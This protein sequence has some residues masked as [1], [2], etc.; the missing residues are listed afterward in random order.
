VDAPAAGVGVGELGAVDA[1]TASGSCRVAR[2]KF[3]TWQLRSFTVSIR[4]SCGR[5]SSQAIDPQNGSIALSTSPM[6]AQA[7][8]ATRPLPP[9]YGNG[10]FSFAI[11]ISPPGVYPGTH[12]PVQRSSR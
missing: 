12:S 1:A 5:A 3:A 4:G 9:K 7:I 2:Q 8:A 11:T 6:R 10:A